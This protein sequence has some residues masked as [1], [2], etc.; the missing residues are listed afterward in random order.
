MATKD[1][2]LIIKVYDG[3]KLFHEYTEQ[4]DYSWIVPAKSS[5]F[6]NDRRIECEF[7]KME[8]NKSNREIVT[9]WAVTNIE[10]TKD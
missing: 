8:F 10:K 2:K 4:F 6:K 3:S 1:I 7:I 9:A 5:F